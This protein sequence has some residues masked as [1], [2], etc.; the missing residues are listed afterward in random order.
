MRSRDSVLQ[1][2]EQR[3]LWLAA[4]IFSLIAFAANSV[5]CRLALRSGDIDP[6]FT[7][8]RLFAGALAL[9]PLYL[10]PLK[11]RSPNG[12]WRGGFY[13]FVYAYLFSLAYVQLDAGVGALIL[14]GAVQITMFALGMQGGEKL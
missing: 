3:W 2:S 8:I 6:S 10:K 9:L 4:T 12:T 13:L 5:F 7:A 11:P 14:F 1:T